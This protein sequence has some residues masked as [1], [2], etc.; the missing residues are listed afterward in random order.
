MNCLVDSDFELLAGDQS[1]VTA[2]ALGVKERDQSE[3]VRI[4]TDRS[5]VAKLEGVSVEGEGT[6]PGLDVELQI[7]SPPLC[8]PKRSLSPDEETS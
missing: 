2:W 1:G 8:D 4:D 3:V 6:V 7:E 5:L